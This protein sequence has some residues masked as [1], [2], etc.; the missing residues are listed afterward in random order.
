[1]F[2]K[3][4]C[5]SLLAA[6]LLLACAQMKQLV[7]V[8]DVKV[9]RVALS[10][11]SF[12][13]VTL[14]FTLLVQN[15]NAFAVSLEGYRFDFSV[16]GK[17]LLAADK[18]DRLDIAA[19]GASTVRL[20]LTV[21]FQ[22]VYRLLREAES[23]DSLSYHLK[24]E[25]RPTGLLSGFRLPFSHSGYLPNVRIPSV[26]LAG[27]SVDRL[28]FTGVDLK[29][30]LKMVNPNSFAFSIGKFEYA[31]ELASNKVMEGATR[32]LAAAPAKGTAELTLPISINFA[33]AMGNLSSL[34]SLLQGDEIRCALRGKAELETPFGP[35]AVPFDT[36]TNLPILK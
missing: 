7:K 22:T 11:F 10:G 31:A 16:L 4:V 14:D 23:L 34:R 18:D 33:G 24:G 35:L 12:E 9:E 36:A 1:M 5:S 17:S 19:G 26:T 29:L 32:R 8:P 27:L 2:R 28:G 20:P 25:L 15:P 6:A 30:N 3:A 13:D 21:N